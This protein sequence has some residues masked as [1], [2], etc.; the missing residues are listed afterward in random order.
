MTPPLKT[1]PGLADRLPQGLTWAAL[2]V[3]VIARLIQYWRQPPLWVDESML[4]VAIGT[5]Q[6]TELASPLA[7][8]QMA[9]VGFTAI[10]WVALKGFGSEEWVLRLLPMVSSIIILILLVL[11]ARRTVS[12]TAT[13]V[14][15][16]G[17]ALSPTLLQYANEVKP[18]SGDAA[19]GLAIILVSLRVVENPARLSRWI[20]WGI[21]TAV[22]AILSFTSVLAAGATG[23]A[24]LPIARKHGRLPLLVG[25]GGIAVMITWVAT[26]TSRP[27]NI[28]AFMSDFW[29]GGFLSASQP[30]RSL[31]KL[32]T[33][34]GEI[35]GRTRSGTIFGVAAWIGA[36]VFFRQ[37]ARTATMVVGPVVVAV[38][39][40]LTQTYPVSERTWLFAAPLFLVSFGVLVDWSFRRISRPGWRTVASFTTAAVFLGPW[41]DL[42]IRRRI[43]FPRQDPKT[44]LAYLE[45]QRQR[46]DE[47]VYIFARATPAWLWYQTDWTDGGGDRIRAMVDARNPGDELFHN[48]PWTKALSVTALAVSKLTTER[49]VELFG[50]PSGLVVRY[51]GPGKADPRWAAADRARIEMLGTPCVWLFA[52][53]VYAHEWR[54]LTTELDRAGWS[55]GPE[56]GGGKDRASRYCRPR[57][58]PTPQAS[59]PR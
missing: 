10:E 33:V 47:P 16:I 45:A 48:Q 49:G 9:P 53:N 37:S 15:V 13:A 34:A 26:S 38:V 2:G 51:E 39:L 5:R 23:L 52:S 20:A 6:F 32:V 42:L 54:T 14:V 55:A 3:G 31:A 1:R 46:A 57:T 29:T 17:A 41:S 30:I 27:P 28:A 19:I 24:L 35:V 40:A 18:Y 4:A 59:P 12:S 7:F 36:V 25:L 21:A 43:A 22:G 56:S 50:G 58:S 8:G 44:P 11:V